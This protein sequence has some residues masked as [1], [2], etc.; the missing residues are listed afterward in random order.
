MEGNFHSFI[1]K[2]KS[3]VLRRKNLLK[4]GYL[5]TKQSDKKVTI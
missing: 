1:L 2:E 4:K 3:R 5:E